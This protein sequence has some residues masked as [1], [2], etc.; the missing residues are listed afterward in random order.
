MNRLIRPGVCL[1]FLLT[2]MSAAAFSESA[3]PGTSGKS[4]S[5]EATGTHLKFITAAILCHGATLSATTHS[6]AV[7]ESRDEAFGSIGSSFLTARQGTL[8]SVKL[9]HFGRL[10]ARKE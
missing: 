1:L 9:W 5:L 8:G 3:N 6:D 2:G 10:S 7:S 4:V